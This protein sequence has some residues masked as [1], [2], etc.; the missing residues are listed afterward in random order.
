MRKKISLV[1]LCLYMYLLL[2]PFY[3]GN[4]GSIQ[5]S[6]FFI[7]ISFALTLIKKKNYNNV[8]K[9]MTKNLKI[10]LLF[11]FLIVSINTIYFF[12]YITKD[13]IMSSAYYIFTAMGIYVFIYKISDDKFLNNIYIICAFNILLQLV[14]FLLGLGRYLGNVRYMGTFNDP[15]QFGFFIILMIMMMDVIKE[16]IKKKNIYYIV[17]FI[18]SCFLIFQAASTGMLLAIG[19]YIVLKFIYL[20]PKVYI[21]IKKYM[22]KIFLTLMLIILISSIALLEYL[23]NDDLQKDINI[24][25]NDKVFNSSF[26][27]RTMEKFDKAQTNDEELLEDRHLEQ[28]LNYPQYLLIRSRSRKL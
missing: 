23:T 21:I 24:F 25:I 5:I 22:L 3:L 14:I 7:I 18:I 2:K 16:I 27:K 9:K 6:D 20:I 10:L 13:Y 8:E 19:T 17:F 12:I 15:N 4:S 28:I 1:N 11:I 26:I